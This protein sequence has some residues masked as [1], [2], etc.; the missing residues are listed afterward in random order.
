[1]P[2]QLAENFAIRAIKAQPLDYATAG[3][4]TLRVSRG[5]G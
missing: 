5:S 3:K 1:V 4:D 2:N